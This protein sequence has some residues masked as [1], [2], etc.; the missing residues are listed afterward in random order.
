MGKSGVSAKKESAAISKALAE[1]KEPT[2]K[3][4]AE[5]SPSALSKYHTD[6]TKQMYSDIEKIVAP[7][8]AKV[9]QPKKSLSE[10]IKATFRNIPNMVR[11]TYDNT[12]GY[13]IS[14]YQNFSTTRALKKEP[15]KSVGYVMNGLAQNIG[16]GWRRGREL[17]KAGLLPYHL[18]SHHY[19]PLEEAHELTLNQIR[20]LHQK[21]KVIEP[22]K[23]SD[24]LMGHSSGG[25]YAIYAAGDK[26]TRE[27]GIKY[28]QAIAPTPYGIKAN[29]LSHKLMGMFVDLSV[30]D[31]TKSRVARE[32]AL[33]MYHRK[34]V[35]PV[36][37]VAG[38][39][40]GLVP[41]EDTV[42]KYA[43]KHHVIHHPKSTHF[44]TSG[45]NSEIN[46]I[47]VD[48]IMEQRGRYRGKEYKAPL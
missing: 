32:N 22:H 38:K 21:A 31:V 26:R 25:N 44:G 18:R 36:D 47:L 29:K 16:P 42:Y 43:D 33:K 8:K 15:G 13:G 23:R 45:S 35:I 48:L 27:H 17:R 39:Y 6:P 1:I 12:V 37:V 10:S 40:D 5:F 20:R 41:V 30:D 2:S 24:H 14:S 9:A 7:Y 4:D 28:A 19:K 11:N 3:K 46:K 34:P